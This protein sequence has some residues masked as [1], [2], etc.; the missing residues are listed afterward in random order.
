MTRHKA[1]QCRFQPRH[2]TQRRPDVGPVAERRIAGVGRQAGIGNLD[3]LDGG[4][5]VHG[6]T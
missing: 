3:P 4:A 2:A 1:S 6:I 5:A